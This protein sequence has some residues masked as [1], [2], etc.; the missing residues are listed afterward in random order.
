MPALPAPLDSYPEF[1]AL[2][3]DSTPSEPAP[4]PTLHPTK[5]FWSYPGLSSD[6]PRDPSDPDG[7]KYANPYAR[8]GSEDPLPPKADVV[9]IGSGITGVSVAYELSKLVRKDSQRTLEVVILEARDF[10]THLRCNICLHQ[11]MTCQ[12]PAQRASSIMITGR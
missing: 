2:Y 7:Y 8:E 9:I 11:L 5:P 1:A 3:K 10:C 6:W 4:L 12:V